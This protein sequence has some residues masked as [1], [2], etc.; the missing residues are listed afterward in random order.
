MIELIVNGTPYTDF[1]SA[2]ATISLESLSND[3]SFIASAVN[4][5]PPFKQGDSVVITVDGVKKITGFID[6]VNGIDQEGSHNIAYTGRDKTG[7]FFDSQINVINDIRA[8]ESLTLKKVIEIV[9][10]HLGLDLKVVDNFNPPPFNQAEDILSPEVGESAFGFVMGYARK[11]QAL[12]SSDGD[13]NILITQSEPT[14]SGA[15]LQ[16]LTRNDSNNIVSQSW[17]INGS[18]RFNKYI[19]RGQL[20]P[21]A[22]SFAG[23]TDIAAVEDQGA[24]ITDDSIRVGRQKVKVETQAYSSDQLKDRAKWAS[25]AAK[26]RATRFNCAVMGHQKPGDAGVWD[27]NTLVQINSDVADISRKMLITT[28]AFSQGE[29]QPTLTSLEFVERNVY[30]INEKLLAQKPVG[31]QNDV[32]SGLG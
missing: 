26:A 13:G 20:D 29:G 23:D 9:I 18:E 3:F 19:H 27:E 12:L 4:A 16:R 6:E 11:R 5:F 31:E 17:T 28:L 2:T 25:Q 32:F 8:D 21:R 30:T 14:E 22:L 1:V 10:A 24:E 15:S 7:D